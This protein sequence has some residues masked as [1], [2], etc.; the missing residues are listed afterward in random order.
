MDLAGAHRLR[1]HVPDTRFC[2]SENAL[3]VFAAPVLPPCAA[4]PPAPLTAA[5]EIS[6]CHQRPACLQRQSG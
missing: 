5:A 1:L 6:S 4:W 2:S 3:V